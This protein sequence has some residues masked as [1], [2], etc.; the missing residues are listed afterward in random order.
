MQKMKRL[1]GDLQIPN[2]IHFLPKLTWSYSIPLI[3]A[4]VFDVAINWM[5]HWPWLDDRGKLFAK[6]ELL[7]SRSLLS[8]RPVISFKSHAS[9]Y[10]SVLLILIKQ[11]YLFHKEHTKNLLCC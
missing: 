11:V 9:I 7:F 10:A 2:F 4:S 5:C 8:G 6:D 3:Y 1:R